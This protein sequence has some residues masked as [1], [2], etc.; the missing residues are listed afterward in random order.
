MLWL[1]CS[2]PNKPFDPVVG[3]NPLSQD[4]GQ[5]EAL[6]YQFTLPRYPFINQS[7]REDELV[8]EL[9]ADCPGQDSNLGPWSCSQVL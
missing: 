3:K 5:C 7:E 1:W 4:T 8:G 2:P 6:D 9:H